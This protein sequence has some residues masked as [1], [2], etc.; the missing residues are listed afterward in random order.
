M[1]ERGQWILNFSIFRTLL[2]M[3]EHC[4]PRL[5]GRRRQ[6]LLDDDIAFGR[7][8]SLTVP[9][10]R[11]HIVHVVDILVVPLQTWPLGRG[12]VT[13]VALE[14][15]DSCMY[16]LVVVEAGS[17]GESLI[18]EI[19]LV[20]LVSRMDPAVGLQGGRLPKCLAAQF[21]AEGPYAL[22]A[23]HVGEK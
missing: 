21:T 14:R 11:W 3:M 22:V 5:K 19:A 12:I 2:V 17:L 7:L 8:S 10:Y 16:L 1:V 6:G 23:S 4:V 15:L 9:E 18:T 20:G 13:H